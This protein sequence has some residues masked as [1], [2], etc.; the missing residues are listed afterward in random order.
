M[1]KYGT[2]RHDCEGCTVIPTDVVDDYVW[3]ESYAD[4]YAML[5]AAFWIGMVAGIVAV[6][7]AQWLKA[8]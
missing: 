2:V 6:R 7:V 3:I 4:T 8:R 1:A 5:T